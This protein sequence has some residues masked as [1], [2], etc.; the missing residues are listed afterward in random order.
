MFRHRGAIF[1]ESQNKGVWLPE[2]DT[3]VPKYVA[4]LIMCYELCLIRCIRWWIY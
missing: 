4:V 1:S 2:E 3:A